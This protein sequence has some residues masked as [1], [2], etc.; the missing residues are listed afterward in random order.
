MRSHKSTILIALVVLLLTGFIAV[1]AQQA[2]AQ[3]GDQK[4]KTESCC[5]MDSCCCN[6]GSCPMMKQEGTTANADAATASTDV[7]HDC[8]ADSCNMN[9]EGATETSA[10]CG[11]CCSSGTCD[12]ANHAKHAK[13]DKKSHAA[14]GSCCK[15]KSKDAKQKDAKEKTN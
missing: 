15:V 13:H 9:K 10:N 1:M 2:P 7:K 3:S 5:A 4:K 12:M 8:C 11:E 6:D 14:D